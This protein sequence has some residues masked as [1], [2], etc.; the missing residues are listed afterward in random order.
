[1]VRS[2]ALLVLVVGLALGGV[3]VPFVFA[4][5][6]PPPDP[7]TP[8]P[9]SHATHEPPPAPK[10]DGPVTYYCPM[11]PSYHS[12]RPGVCPICSMALVP[13]NPETG[14]SSGT[15]GRATVTVS[16]ERRQLIGVRTAVVEKKAVAKTIR[17]VGRV[18]FNEKALSTVNLKF[19]GWVEEL[20]VKSTGEL[21]KKGSPLLSLY[22]PEILEAERNLVLAKQAL[23]TIGADSGNDAKTFAEDNLRFARDRL[24]LWDM[25]DEQIAEIE[26]KGQPENRVTLFA[27]VDGVVTRR[28]VVQGS[29]FE[30]GKNLFEIADLSTVW[31]NADVY[32]YELPD[33]ALG[34]E[35]TV[36]LPS[37]PD[38]AFTGKVVYI[39]PYLNEA[40]RT[41]RVRLELPNADRKLKPGMY[42]QVSIAVD[43]GEQLVVDESAVVFSGT[44]DIVFVDLGEGRLEPREVTIGPRADGNIVIRSGLS[45]GEKA[46]VSGNFLVDSESRLKS[47]LL[48]GA[49][50]SGHKHGQ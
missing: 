20:F 9:Q 15:E 28:D 22:S 47:A 4:R 31:I 38:A 25:T 18:D 32:E 2:P 21:V 45:A 11:H 16:P 6:A 37:A 10:P 30:P 23:S 34:Q 36:R 7:P 29:S 13:M 5:L 8:A 27:K 35:A 33:V 48:Q 40:T 14:A 3:L 26:S 44:R 1:M 49:S 24:R 17:A 50:G 41:N 12:D 39:Y 19:G 46:V 42:T 43:L